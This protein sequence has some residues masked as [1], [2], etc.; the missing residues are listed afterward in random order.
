MVRLNV[1]FTSQTIL[2]M[3]SL[4]KEGINTHFPDISANVSEKVGL[5]GEVR[6][7]FEVCRHF[8]KK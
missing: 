6:G 5:P 2:F 4:V 1:R 3:S 7:G 8:R